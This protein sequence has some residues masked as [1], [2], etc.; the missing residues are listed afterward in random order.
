VKHLIALDIDGTL[1]RYDQEISTEVV[2]A[3]A[4]VV[5]AGHQ[6]V[7]ATGRTVV[8]L[9][10]FAAL[11]G[12]T[13]GYAVASNGAVTVWLDPDEPGGYRLVDVITFDPGPALRAL[14][15]ELP[16]ALI[17]VEDL[18]VGARVTAPFPDGELSGTMTVVDFDELASRPATRVVL[19]APDSAPDDFHAAVARVGLHEVSYTVG[20]TAW[21][22]L[23]PGGVSKASALESIRQKLGMEPFA[24]VAVG[25]GLN[26]VEM[27]QWAARG[28]AMANAPEGLI[29][30]ADEVTGPVDEDGVVD[31]LRS[32]L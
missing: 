16:D 12:I 3:V 10:E 11:A 15:L 5:A 27:L 17:A 26:D 7:L 30:V 22:D 1:L 20:W 28:V 32:L 18:G 13:S 25:D 14:A 31:V 21:L 9:M 24:T 4:E 23:T 29:L 19:R 6:V 2:D 8:A